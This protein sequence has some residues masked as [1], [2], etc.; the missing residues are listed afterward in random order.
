MRAAIRARGWG[1][2]AFPSPGRLRSTSLSASPF[3]T[4]VSI[5]CVRRLAFLPGVV[6]GRAAGPVVAE[7][8]GEATGTP[9]IIV[10]VVLGVPRVGDAVVERRGT[11]DDDDGDKGT[12]L[13]ALNGVDCGC[14]VVF[15][16][17]CPLQMG[18]VGFLFAFS[19][20]LAF[21]GTADEVGVREG[22]MRGGG[23]A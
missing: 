13:V 1:S 14:C 3:G 5:Q 21:W 16:F 2:E 4:S 10:V 9:T 15:I 12:G 22:V 18:L 6:H 11:P 8:E 7:D 17:F 19:F 23:A 20:S